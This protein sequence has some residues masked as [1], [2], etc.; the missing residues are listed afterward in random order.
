MV[1][2]FNYILFV[3][4]T[5]KITTNKI[6][7]NFVFFCF[8]SKIK[9]LFKINTSFSIEHHDYLVGNNQIYVKMHDIEEKFYE[10]IC[11]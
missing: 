5:N 7:S 10:M 11:K 9:L 2:I 8:P 1:I 3:S 4:K 6:S